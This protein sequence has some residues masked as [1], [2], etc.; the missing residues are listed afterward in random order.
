VIHMDALSSS[1]EDYFAKEEFLEGDSRRENPSK[2]PK[3]ELVLLEAFIGKG[4]NIPLKNKLEIIPRGGSWFVWKT[5]I[6]S[7]ESDIFCTDCMYTLS[8]KF[9]DN[10]L[11]SFQAKTF[12]KTTKIDG[13]A[14]LDGVQKGMLNSYSFTIREAYKEEDFVLSVGIQ[15]G[16]VRVYVDC[17]TQ[18]DSSSSYAWNYLVE[19]SKEILFTKRP[20]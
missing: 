18:P 13:T 9:S 19:N 11:I 8:L 2:G 12:K 3:E 1:I 6:I 17:D 16:K 10:T 14:T 5:M 7:K 4:A 20:L 15:Q